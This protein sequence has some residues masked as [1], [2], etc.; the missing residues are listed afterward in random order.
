M[1]DELD[2]IIDDDLPGEEIDFDDIAEE[3]PEPEEKEKPETGISTVSQEVDDEK[4][5]LKRERDEARAESARIAKERDDELVRIDTEKKNNLRGNLNIWN[6]DA[7]SINNDMANLRSAYDIAKIE[8]DTTKMQSISAEY[9]KKNNQLENLKTHIN[10]A[11]SELSK[12]AP[13]PKKVVESEKKTPEL[14]ETQRMA[15]KWVKENP[16]F[17]DPEHLKKREVADTAY[18]K[19]VADGYDPTSIKF[20]KFIDSQVEKASTTT[21]RRTAPAVRPVNSNGVPN[22][23]A[24]NGNKADPTILKA[25]VKLLN[26][27]GIDTSDRTDPEVKRL[28][29]SY[30]R[31]AKLNSDL[32]VKDKANA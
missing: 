14:T 31:T 12:P 13:E 3:I 16:W 5:T 27:R 22:K 17:E 11:N 20:W 21:T 32:I 1:A 25:A 7:A 19:A 18:K 4:E 30:Y 29:K 8:Q 10:A 26:M 9:N 28:L 24:N 6:N 23:M 2:D 15:A